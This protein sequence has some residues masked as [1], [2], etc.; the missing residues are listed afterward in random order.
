VSRIK[1]T[2]E[3]DGSEFAGWQIQPGQR[4]VQGI[5]EEGLG[6]F[7]GHEVKITG[8]GRTDAGVHAAGQTAHFDLKVDRTERQI[9]LGGN[10]HLPEDVAIVQAEFVAE[11]FHARYDAVERQYRYQ[12]LTRSERPAYQRQY[13]GDTRF[14]LDEDRV[15]AGVKLMCGTH[16]FRSFRSVLCEAERTVLDLDMTAERV[17]DLWI[18]DFRARSFL[19]HMIRLI[20]GTMIE[21]GRERI[22]CDKVGEML[23]GAPRPDSIPNAPAKGLTLMCVRY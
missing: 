19:H 9:S 23:R 13:M 14:R 2:L 20:V 7:C 10:E 1:L 8:A 17:G 21:L 22:D 5:L 4:T 11:N 16:E 18:F 12:L 3:Y 6:Q 15:M